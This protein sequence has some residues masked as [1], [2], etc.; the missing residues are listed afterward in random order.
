[1]QE[2]R[3]KL[4]DYENKI[5]L[6]GQEIE[7]LNHALEDKIRELNAVTSQITNVQR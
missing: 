5:A 4:S 3:R 2:Y 7:R 1:M 6:F